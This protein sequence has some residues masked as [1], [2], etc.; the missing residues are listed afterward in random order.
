MYTWKLSLCGEQR[1]S[2]DLAVVLV[3]NELAFHFGEDKFSFLLRNF[4]HS[5]VALCVMLFVGGGLF[6]FSVRTA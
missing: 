6:R 4:T 2:C 3:V 1:F 5:S